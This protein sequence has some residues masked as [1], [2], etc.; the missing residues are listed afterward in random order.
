M[1]AAGPVPEAITSTTEEVSPK[2]G[3]GD[4]VKGFLF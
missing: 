2:S 4:T 1:T 3:K